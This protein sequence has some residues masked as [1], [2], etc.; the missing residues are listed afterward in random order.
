[1]DIATLIGIIGG[2]AL[3]IVSIVMGSPISAFLNAPG[4]T[5]VIGGTIMA[6]LI[7]QRLKVVLGAFKVAGKAFL[8]QSESP[9]EIK[10]RMVDL[11]AKAKKDGML[12]L[13]KEEIPNKFLARGIKMAVDGMPP[14]D[15]VSS[16]ETDLD[17]L[18]RRHETGQRVFRFMGS[19]AP[20]MGMIG[21]LIGLV[22]MLRSLDDPANIGPSM[23]VALLT[24]FYG[25]VL[26]FLVFIPISEKLKD[27]TDQEALI[28][29][30]I[31]DGIKGITKG[32]SPR[33]LDDR[34]VSFLEPAKREEKSGEKAA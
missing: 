4:L 16:L 2:F 11:A 7:M 13:E 34:L 26:A 31:I 20:S 1:M 30:L 23:A 22:Q 14:E 27:R 9:E 29:E 18:L 21:T 3:I 12:A 25:A 32:L 33:V 6:T 19:T 8:I 28:K 17:V 15:I 24:T 5:I 10:K